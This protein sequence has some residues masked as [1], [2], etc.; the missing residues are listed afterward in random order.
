MQ[1]RDTRA[2]APGPIRVDFLS[3]LM[4][5]R[6][7]GGRRNLAARAVGLKPGRPAP[8]V[9]DATAGL[10]R[11]SWL[12]AA[13]GCEVAAIER[14]PIV[15]AL[16]RDG[17]DRARPEEPE[18][19]G[20]IELIEAEAADYLADH[21]ADVVLLDPMFPERRKSALVKKEM[22]YFS[23]L[24]GMENDGAALF[25]PACRASARV[26]VKRPLHAAA[27]VTEPGPTH[28]LKGK[29]VRYDVYMH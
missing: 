23:A 15:A 22:R 29:S 1:L 14:S 26:V 6:C 20:R 18:I 2:G 10:G 7:A 19:C 9:I 16:L 3:A 12:L 8:R 4:A 13:L 21:R 5:R 27:L 17:L 11:D 25:E 24:L 28:V